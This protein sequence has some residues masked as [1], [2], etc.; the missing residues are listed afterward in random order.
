MLLD[1]T[2]NLAL[3]AESALERLGDHD[4]LVYDRHTYRSGQLA[5][6][7]RR[8]GAG[9][10]QLG[11][12]PGDRVVALMANCPEVGITYNAVWRAGGV[13]TPVMFLVSGTE[14]GHILADSGAQ[15]VVTSPELL[16]TIAAAAPAAPALRQVVLVGEA[17]DGTPDLP[18]GVRLTAFADLESAAP[19]DIVLRGDDELAALLYTGGT[20]GRAKGVMLSHRNLRSCA[21]STHQAGQED[22]LA[23]GINRTLIPLPLSHAYGLIVTLVGWHAVEPQLAILQRWFAPAEWLALAQEYRV[24]RTTLVPSMIQ[25]LLAQPLEK[26]DLSELRHVA[27]GAAPL[28]AE[29]R[30]EWERVVPG[31]EILE[32]YG[33]TESGSVIATTRPGRI[34]PGSVGLPLPGYAIEIRDDEG[35]AVPAGSPGEICVRSAGVMS[36]YWHSPEQTAQA[37]RDGWLQTGDIGTLDDEGFLFIVDRKKDLIL[38]GGFN[39]YPRDVEDALLTHPKVAAAAVVGQPDPRLGEEVV[40][41]VALRPGC[42]LDDGELGTYARTQLSAHKYPREVHVLDRLPLTSVGKLDRKALRGLTRA[43]QT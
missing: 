36:G 4:A 22:G 16:P 25:M 39:V 10:T 7:A 17:P 27:S 21:A 26:A 9:L 3:L 38:R 8:V 20:T 19:A 40:A 13:V 43:E 32:G 31:S 30:A 24:Q 18:G 34:R 37:L 42:S 41:F 29:V 28:P 15:V 35:R 11:V 6:R 2:L 14:L 12:R 33:C 23:E 5:E 1:H